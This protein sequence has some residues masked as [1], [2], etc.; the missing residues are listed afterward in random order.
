[1]IQY[2]INL[3]F[4]KICSGCSNILLANENIICLTCRHNLPLTNDLLIENNESFKKFYGRLPL[5]HASV[6][7]SFSKK[8]IVQKLIHNLKYTNQQEIGT[9]LGNWYADD[10]KNINVLQHADFIIPVPLHKKRLSS[11]GYN[12]ISTFSEAIANVL[13]VKYDPDVLVRN[14]YASMQNKKNLI[15]RNDI[16]GTTF[17]VKYN[18]NHYNKHFIIVDDVLTTGATLEA[19]G[20]AILSIPGAKIS[21]V[22]IAMS[23][24]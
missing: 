8:G 13:R 2:L 1:M 6:M 22:C 20:K 9:V 24:S 4:P 16:S 7:L 21:I 5:Q 10:L 17:A 11:R 14:E 12:Q 18:E 23:K 15:N 19:C 3:F